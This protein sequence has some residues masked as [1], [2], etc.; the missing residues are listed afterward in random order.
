MSTFFLR[1]EVSIRHVLCVSA[2]LYPRVIHLDPPADWPRVQPSTTL[3]EMSSASREWLVG[4]QTTVCLADRARTL[5]S[6]GAL[7]PT[8]TTGSR[9]MPASTSCCSSFQHRRQKSSP[10]PLAQ[11][12]SPMH[13]H[14]APLAT[15]M[16]NQ[17]PL[18]S[19]ESFRLARSP[20][21]SPATLFA[22]AA[23]GDGL[24]SAFQQQYSPPSMSVPT[25]STSPIKKRYSAP[26]ETC[27]FMYPGGGGA[28]E[29]AT[30]RRSDPVVPV[31]LESRPMSDGFP[32]TLADGWIDVSGRSSTRGTTGRW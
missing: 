27:S 1:L 10:S 12:R 24:P 29:D 7:K 13:R 21:S 11:A 4:R 17:L 9:S 6:C 16:G 14:L 22:P 31:S 28:A 23:A 26:L 8:S 3:R 20:S 15:M 19:P 30:R 25:F 32:G 5:R 2:S 18:A